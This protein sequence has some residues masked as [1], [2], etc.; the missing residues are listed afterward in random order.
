V[1]KYNVRERLDF[2]GEV[3]AYMG[4]EWDTMHMFYDPHARIFRWLQASGCSCNDISDDFDSMQS[5]DEMNFGRLDEAMNAV[6][7]Y[8]TTSTSSSWSDADP[9]TMRA[10]ADTLKAAMRN[11]RGKV[12]EDFIQEGH[13][14]VLA[15]GAL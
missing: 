12:V 2:L 6:D 4:Y 8:V 10:E 3:D 7:Q 1:A 5:P 9:V 15:F 11:C 13:Q 14:P